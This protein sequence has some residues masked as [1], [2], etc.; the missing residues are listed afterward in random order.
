MQINIIK[1]FAY[2]VKCM[3]SLQDELMKKRSYIV[4]TVRRTVRFTPTAAGKCDWTK[5][6]VRCPIMI[7]R[8]VGRH[9]VKINPV[10][11][12]LNITLE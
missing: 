12:R 3:S 10:N 5:R 11:L 2:Y 1:N 7:V 9:V 4:V 8:R 6:V